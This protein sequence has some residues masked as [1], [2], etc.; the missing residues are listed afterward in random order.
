[1]EA[2]G[3]F[4]HFHRLGTHDDVWLVDRSLDITRDFQSSF[5]E[6]VLLREKI[7]KEK[8]PEYDIDEIVKAFELMEEKK[9]TDYPLFSSEINAYHILRRELALE[10]GRK[11]YNNSAPSRLHSV[12][13]TDEESLYYW[14]QYVGICGRLFELKV[15]GE[16]F[17]SSDY[18]FPDIKA[19]FEEQVVN[20]KN[21]WKPK[22]LSISMPKEYLFQGKIEIKGDKII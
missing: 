8:Y 19:S 14:V 2:K 21:Y 6:N 11:I 18:L 15:D 3:L 4:Y 20:S 13:L 9:D 17:E 16:I 22:K 1:M 12:Y 7:L 5:Y 10:E